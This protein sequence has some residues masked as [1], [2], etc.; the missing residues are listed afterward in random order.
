MPEF[1]PKHID[2]IKHCGRVLFIM[3]EGYSRKKGGTLS[4]FLCLVFVIVCA[5]RSQ[6]YNR[7]YSPLKAYKVETS[8]YNIL[9]SVYLTKGSDVSLE[10]CRGGGLVKELISLSFSDMI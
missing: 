1:M 4:V 9:L 5:L 7:L 3:Q 8:K 10:G 6:N 2:A